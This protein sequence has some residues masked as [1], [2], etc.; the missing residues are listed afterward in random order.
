[1]ENVK[2]MIIVGH[3]GAGKAVL[4]KALA[5]R[6]NWKFID[7]DFGLELQIGWPIEKILSEQGNQAFRQ[8]ENQLLKQYINQDKIV[9]VTDAG[10]VLSEENLAQLSKEYVVFVDVSLPAALDRF[11]RGK[12]QLMQDT[13]LKTLLET[14]HERDGLFTKVANITTLTDDGR[15][16][17]HIHAVLTD[18]QLLDAIVDKMNIQLEN[19]DLIQLHNETYESV[20]LT[21]QQA[22]CLKLLAHGKSSKEIA[23]DLDISYRT[24][25][26]HIAKLMELLGCSSSKELISLYLMGRP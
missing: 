25:E 1:M 13:E 9:L 16:D 26:G 22:I 21:E 19:S 3:P 23:R 20:H 5:E 18:A 24:V 8:C 4:G 15:V 6:L 17:A 2:R 10:I 11:Q 14:I 12:E 7:A